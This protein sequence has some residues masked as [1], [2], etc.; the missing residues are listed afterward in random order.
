[1]DT[2]RV[3]LRLLGY[4]KKYLGVG[5]SPQHNFRKVCD[6]YPWYRRYNP[7]RHLAEGLQ[8]GS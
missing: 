7:V 4:F 5:L 3:Y 1:M 6:V 8:V 2:V